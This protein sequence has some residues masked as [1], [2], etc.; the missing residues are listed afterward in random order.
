MLSIRNRQFIKN[1]KPFFYYAD[2]CWSAFTNINESDW[3]YYLDYREQQGFN[4]IQINILKQWDASGMDLNIY[5]FE[6]S[7]ND[8][9]YSFDYSKINTA[10]FDRAEKMLADMKRH[11]MIPA[12][13]LLWSNYVPGTWASK[14]ARN[15]MFTFNELSHYVEYVTKRF[16]KFNPIYF[17]SGD[18]D[19]P[20]EETNK[21]YR[22]VLKTA[23]END[24]DAL[25]SFHIKGRFSDVPEEFLSQMDFF[26]YQSGHN[27]DGQAT[28]HTI[29]T[30]ER[31]KFSGP[32]INTEPCYDQISYSRNKYGRFSSHDVRSA[33]WRS[34]LSGANAGITYG[35]HGIWSWHHTGA[36]FGV[37]AGEGFDVPFDWHDALHFRGATD[38][39]FLKQTMLNTFPNGCRPTNIQLNHNDEIRSATNPE[40]SCY[41]V[42]LPTNT[43]LDISPLGLDQNN[44]K[45]TIFDLQKRIQL[46]GRWSTP[47]IIG[48]PTCLEDVLVKIEKQEG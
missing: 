2:T 46:Q 13:V 42:Y 18:T 43:E 35:A 27:I 29:P 30:N 32:I 45:I 1:S 47:S 3:N 11:H 33:A 34:V 24:P 22:E 48:L 44:A 5:P 19:F 8:N 17:I 15:N 26:S 21:Y 41:L 4:V 14:L 38:L 23:K 12:L 28:A 31:A 39:A 7:K 20:T 16:K 9:G 6:I 36:S 40:Q 25:Y 10:Y 37:V